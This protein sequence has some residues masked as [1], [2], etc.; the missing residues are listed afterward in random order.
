MSDDTP[1]LSCFYICFGWCCFP[2]WI[3]EEYKNI[4][5]I[6]INAEQIENDK[7]RKH[8]ILIKNMSSKNECKCKCECVNV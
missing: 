6:K 7:Q 8:E 5:L 3:V 1:C 2:C 4:Q